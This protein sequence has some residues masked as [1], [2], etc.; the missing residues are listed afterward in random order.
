VVA[1]AM[2]GLV[3]VIAN[4]AQG[5]PREDTCLFMFNNG[6]D[7]KNNRKYRKPFKSFQVCE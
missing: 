7:L 1:L 2:T 3:D 5:G 4:V 6:I